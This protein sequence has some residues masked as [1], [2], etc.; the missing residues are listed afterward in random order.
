MRTNQWAIGID[1]GGTKIEVALVNSSGLLHDRLRVPTNSKKGYNAILGLIA[2]TIHQLCEKNGDII[3]SDVGIGIPGQISRSSGIVHYA[4]NLNWHEVNLGND[5]SKMIGKHV[6]ICNDVRA[7]TWGE[8][9]HGAGKFCNDIVCIFIGTG[10]G[11]GIVS[12]GRMLA[13]CN[14]TAGEIGH[15]TIDL[16]GPEC[17]CGNKGCFE[18]L[19]GG[20]AIARDAQDMVKTDMKSGRIL[21][22]IAGN[23][24]NK[25]TAKTVS[26]A[27]SKNDKL[28]KKIIDNLADALIAGSTALVNAYAPC[29]L[30]LGGG[31]MEGMPQLI[32]RIEKGVKKYAL[33][34]AS[35]NLK[36]L[37]AKL[38]NDSGVIGAAAFALHSMDKT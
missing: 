24:I 3:P 13:G 17:H 37:P 15:M 27:A 12:D 6:R 2:K 14:N 20:W 23:E 30:I 8:W 10:I 5:L 28:A 32:E 18:A 31:I 33:K 22:A 7:A 34:A 9:L 19:A 16:H 1:L 29:R 11:G 26:E 36:V 38:H 4:P 25:I 35:E 21:L